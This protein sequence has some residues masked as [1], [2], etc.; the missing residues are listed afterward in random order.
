MPRK[1]L[2]LLKH[3]TL[4]DDLRRPFAASILRRARAI[5]VRYRIVLERDA[6]LGYLGSSIE[7]PGVMADGP[8]P[9]ACVRATMEALEAA[10]ATLL[11]L[12]RRPPSPQRARVRT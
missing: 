5:A 8:T 6:D 11:E 12:G 1:S 7:M 2:S 10:I 3:R 4:N 9:D